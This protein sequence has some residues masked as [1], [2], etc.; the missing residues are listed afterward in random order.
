MNVIAIPLLVRIYVSHTGASIPTR[1][2]TFLVI[3][4]YWNNLHEHV[5][6]TSLFVYTYRC[7]ITIR[8]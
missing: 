4:K 6:Y 5:V 7:E 8:K 1:P 3:S 2:F